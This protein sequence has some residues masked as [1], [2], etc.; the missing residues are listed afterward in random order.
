[1]NSYRILPVFRI[2]DFSLIHITNSDDFSITRSSNDGNKQYRRRI[3]VI[4]SRNH[5]AQLVLMKTGDPVTANMFH[6]Y[7][8]NYSL[9]FH[10]LFITKF[11]DL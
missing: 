8:T 5:F 9:F 6:S 3:K 2:P 11:I 1:M 4:L 10:P 7:T